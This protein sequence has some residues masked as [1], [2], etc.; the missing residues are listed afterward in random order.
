M[1]DATL[2]GRG[3]TGRGGLD[4][5]ASLLRDHGTVTWPIPTSLLCIYDHSQMHGQYRRKPAL[6]LASRNHVP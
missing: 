1:C 5:G 2:L 6:Y 3:N 4:F